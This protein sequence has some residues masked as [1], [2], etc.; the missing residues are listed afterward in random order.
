MKGDNYQRHLDKLLFKHFKKDFVRVATPGCVKGKRV[1]RLLKCVPIFEA[2]NHEYKQEG[3]NTQAEVDAKVSE[4]ND[5]GS[6]Y[7]E[8]PL[9][10]SRSPTDPPIV[11]FALYLD[12][13]RYTRQIGAR[14][15][16]IL[17]FAAYNLM[18]GKRHVICIAHKKYFCK[19]G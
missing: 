8:H 18:S 17:L 16:H 5:W 19:C 1:K 7:K 3:V 2:L 15:Q 13:I 6:F 10:T 9:V 11:P 14:A 4:A 12:A